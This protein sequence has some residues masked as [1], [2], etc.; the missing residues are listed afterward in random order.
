MIAGR[1]RQLL[2]LDTKCHRA[3]A[4]VKTFSL[5]IIFFLPL[6]AAYAADNGLKIITTTF[7]I[8][9]LTKNITL[10]AKGISV[11]III[12]STAGCPHGYNLTPADA[13]KISFADMM[14]INGLGLD[15]HL[16]LGMLPKDS[17]V[18]DTSIGMKNVL[19][20]DGEHNKLS[21]GQLNPHLFASPRRYA[22]MLEIILEELVQK[23]GEQADLFRKNA[24]TYKNKL[25]KLADDFSILMTGL[26]YPKVVTQHNVFE[27][28]AA[29][30][31]FKIIDSIQGHPGEAPSAA[32][33]IKLINKIKANG[34]KAIFVEPQFDDKYAKTIAMETEVPLVVLDPVAS[35][36][37]NAPLDYYEKV[38]RANMN[39]LKRVLGAASR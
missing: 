17:K 39:N 5:I 3:A 13:R 22:F 11:D 18:I 2:E 23:D 29:D 28:L 32:R 6:S 12:Q 38:M 30:T 7:P 14:M 37:D 1:N 20:N 25:R 19:K 27:Y 4:Q 24:Q 21:H 35:G 10:G 34:A 15:N 36:P 16:A 8:Y 9:Q 26:K 33:I 31:G